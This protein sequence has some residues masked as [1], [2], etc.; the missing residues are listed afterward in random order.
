MRVNHD[1]E[2]LVMRYLV[3]ELSEE[4]QSRLE[5][6]LFTDD[7]FYQELR[8]TERDLID[9][10]VRGRLSGELH[11]QFER[12]YMALPEG[13]QKVELA[14]SFQEYIAELPAQSASQLAIP[15]WQRVLTSVGLQSSVLQFSLTAVA[16]VL[17]IGSSWLAYRNSQLRSEFGELQATQTAQEKQLQAQLAAAR[18]EAE[19]ERNRSAQLEQTLAQQPQGQAPITT[20]VRPPSEVAALSGGEAPVTGF[21]SSNR[22]GL[23]GPNGTLVFDDQ[24]S[25]RWVPYQGATG[26]QV[27]VIDSS[28][29]VIK[30]SEQVP[31][32]EWKTPRALQRGKTYSWEVIAFAGGQEIAKSA[33]G[34][35][36]IL[37]QGKVDF[38]VRA[39]RQYANSRLILGVIYTQA[40]LLDD[41]ERE[42]TAIIDSPQESQ[43]TRKLARQLLSSVK[44]ARNAGAKTMR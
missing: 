25:F 24:P 12:H 5:E 9:A 8:A 13:R 23:I 20:L 15:W 44:V 29:N 16:V 42:F 19:R 6:Q 2:K 34:R 21:G 11:Q 10:Y 4:E 28:G 40:G 27:Q 17:L 31:E 38:L 39:Q 33:A 41:A 1:S 3:G 35:I 43:D 7:E 37:E 18:D 36:K 22:F 30:S 14:R 26:Y 32:T